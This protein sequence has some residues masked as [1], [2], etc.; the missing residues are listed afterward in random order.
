MPDH[1]NLGDHE[2]E[3]CPRC[4]RQRLVRLRSMARYSE[5]DWFKC[6]GCDHLF[7]RPRPEPVATAID[8]TTATPTTH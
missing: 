3:M 5:L 6:D 2:A 8:H 4:H 1:V 7:T